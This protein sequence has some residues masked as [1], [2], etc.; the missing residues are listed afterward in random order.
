[1]RAS[2]APS[3]TPGRLPGRLAG[4]VLLPLI[5]AG[6]SRAAQAQT[7]QAGDARQP[8]SFLIDATIRSGSAGGTGCTIDLDLRQNA[9]LADISGLLGVDYDSRTQV[10][11]FH[12]VGAELGRTVKT[13]IRAPDCDWRRAVVRLV[14]ID[15]CR[16]NG[17]HYE[18][19]IER[20][21]GESRRM[22]ERTSSGIR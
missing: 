5:A 17:R 13:R 8:P 14:R 12:F 18:D 1:M 19:C 6:T 15:T 11:P 7:T 22:G 9:G 3:R 21:A 10:I 4:A 20:V 16:V 2:R